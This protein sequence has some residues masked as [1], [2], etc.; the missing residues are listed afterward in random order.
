VGQFSDA[1]GNTQSFIASPAAVTVP[2]TF[3]LFGSVLVGLIGFN[4]RKT[5]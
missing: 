2:S 3:L 5:T 1:S 4:R